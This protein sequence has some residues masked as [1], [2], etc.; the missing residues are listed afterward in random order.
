MLSVAQSEADRTS[1]RIKAV[2]EYRRAKG[3]YIG[4]APTGY[5]IVNKHLVKDEEKQEGMEAFFK[6]YLS[7]FSIAKALH[8]ASRYGVLF[9][10]THIARLIKNTAYCGI[11]ANGYQCDPYITVE[12]HQLIIDKIKS[13]TVDSTKTNEIYLFSGLLKCGYCGKTLAAKSC[14]RKRKNGF[15]RYTQYIC[16][17]NSGTRSFHKSLSIYETKIENYLLAELDTILGNIINNAQTS[18]NDNARKKSL[19]YKQSLEAK[20]K[21]VMLLYEEGD[22]D[23]IQYRQRRNEINAE[24]NQIYMPPVKVPVPLPEHWQEVYQELTPEFKK[25][26]W[27]KTIK[28]ITITRDECL[29]FQVE[30]R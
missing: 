18:A 7:T 15:K 20:L 25:A 22:I 2:N 16:S 3:E 5:K 30:F 13:N 11:A 1:E 21:R 12:E 8:E 29:H 17:S 4:K 28:S 27:N 23:I 19:S 24:I 10:R 6:E 9:E 14:K 26:F